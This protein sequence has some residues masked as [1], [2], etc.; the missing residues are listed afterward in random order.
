MDS[1]AT[2]KFSDVMGALVRGSSGLAA[3]MAFLVVVP[4]TL[5]FAWARH[6][7]L[8]EPIVLTLFCLSFAWLNMSILKWQ[9]TFRSLGQS[10]SARLLLGPRPEDQDE[11]LVWQWGRQFR[12]AFLA[13]VVCMIAFG[14]IKWLNGE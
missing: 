2:R 1:H 10:S 8:A 7:T 13:V 6:S 11:L 5:W 9:R 12:Y 3:L 14:F 4:F